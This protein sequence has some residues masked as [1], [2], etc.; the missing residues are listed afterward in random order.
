MDGVDGTESLAVHWFELCVMLE[1]C[2]IVNNIATIKF[3]CAN[4]SIYI[5]RNEEEKREAKKKK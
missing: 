1:D 5:Q 3:Y 4:Y 2:V